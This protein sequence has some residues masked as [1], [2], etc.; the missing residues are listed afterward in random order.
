LDDFLQVNHPIFG[1]IFG[2]L[3]L[4]PTSHWLM[5]FLVSA[6]LVGKKPL[7]SAAKTKLAWSLPK[8]E[9]AAETAVPYTW[10]NGVLQ[11]V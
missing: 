1:R 3:G 2:F 8:N 4:T 10:S 5:V 6:N 11:K 9:S 7:N